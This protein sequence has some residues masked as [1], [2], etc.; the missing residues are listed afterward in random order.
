MAL[1]RPYALAFEAIAHERRGRRGLKTRHRSRGV[2]RAGFSA[3]FPLTPS[4]GLPMRSRR[5]ERH[6]QPRAACEG[7]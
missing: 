7:K 3:L 2:I 5:F 1:V 6:P 4:R